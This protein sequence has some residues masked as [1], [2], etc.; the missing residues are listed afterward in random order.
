MN[1]FPTGDCGDSRSMALGRARERRARGVSESRNGEVVGSPTI[2]GVIAWKRAVALVLLSIAAGACETNR[3]PADE[4]SPERQVKLPV[5][6]PAVVPRPT[7]TELAAAP[8][9]ELRAESSSAAGVGPPPIRLTKGLVVDRAAGEVRLEAQSAL[10]AGWLEQAICLAGTREHESLLVIE[11]SPRLVHAALMML[12]LE[13]GRPGRWRVDE[14]NGAILRIPPEGPRL[15]ILL[16]FRHPTRGEIEEPL[17][18]WFLRRE[19]DSGPPHPWKFAGSLE[20]TDPRGTVYV[21]E[22][23]G[24]VAGLVTFGDEVIAHE[25]VRSDLVEIEHEPYLVAEDRVPPPGTPVT[26]VIRPVR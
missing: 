11:T 23:S 20:E 18:R 4:A 6:P 16:R 26:V 3:L 2:R 12:G 13:P 7:E 19:G 9:P 25:E 15:E 8:S 14:G 21:A 22:F 17:S 1:L 24:S 5:E 10:D